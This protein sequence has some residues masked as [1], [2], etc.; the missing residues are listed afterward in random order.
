M[1]RS[2]FQYPRRTCFLL[3]TAILVMETTSY[4]PII[5]MGIPT[6]DNTNT[7]SYMIYVAEMFRNVFLSIKTSEANV[8]SFIGV[9]SYVMKNIVFV[10]SHNLLHDLI[11]E[12]NSLLVS[13]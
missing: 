4:L 11:A 1:T 10:H 13:Y 8:K 9:M 12:L 7:A 3:D 5:E 6:K 2:D